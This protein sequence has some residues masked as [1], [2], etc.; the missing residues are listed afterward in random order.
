MAGPAPLDPGAP[1]LVRVRGAGKRFG[2]TQA[3]DGVDFDVHGGS[4]VALL[5]A[6]GAGKSTLIKALA[7]VYSLDTGT[8]E[9]VGEPVGTPAAQAR[10]AFIHQDLGLVDGLTVAENVALGTGYPRRRGLIAWRDVRRRADRALE[11]IGADVDPRARVADLSRTER[12]LVAIGRALVVDAKVLV[13]DEPTASL[14]V[15]ETHRLLAVVRS[16]RDE[17]L[18]IVYVTHRLDEV[19]TI[20]DEVVVMRDGRVVETTPLSR[21]SPDEV[22]GHIVGRKPVPPPPPAPRT[23][24]QPA[25]VLDGVVGERV[26]PVSLTVRRGEVVGLVGLAGAG[27]VETGRT[28]LGDSRCYA[29]RLELDGKP[30]RPTDVPTAVR[31]GLG[32]VTS[33]RAAEGLAMGLTCT[34]NLLPNPALQGQKPW[35]WRRHGVER[36]RAAELVRTFGVRPADPDLPVGGLSG[37][38]QQKVIL[39]RWLST[40]ASVLVLEEPTAGV[41]VGA[42]HEIYTL[43]DAA[44][45]RGLAVLLISTD[46]EEVATVCHRALV[47]RDGEIVREITAN[48]LSV[49]TLVALASGAAA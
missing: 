10:I 24:T 22:V 37:G 6:N 34:E 49:T 38:N 30:Y 48:D 31:R 4:V 28:I 16:L 21:T 8:A 29:G 45:E 19:F 39:G 33:D 3:L 40:D 17:G 47:F 43:L 44:L 12:S 5:G 23:G 7:G 42:K 15:D 36:A 2:A 41:D 1:P 32:L 9:I 13:L 26:G 35:T 20:A 18:G 46:F 25:L 27:H 11:L 14:P